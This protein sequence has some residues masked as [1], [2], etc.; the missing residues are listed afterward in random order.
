M[1]N[2]QLET[3]PAQRWPICPVPEPSM[4]QLELSATSAR[5]HQ[6]ILS[7]HRDRCCAVSLS[8][9]EADR[10]MDSE[11]MPNISISNSDLTS[12]AIKTAPSRRY[13]LIPILDP[14]SK[15]TGSSSS[16]SRNRIS[17][18]RSV[19]LQL[20]FKSESWTSYYRQHWRNRSFQDA[21]EGLDLIKHLYHG[22]TS[23]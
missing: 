19:E 8:T 4:P 11:C 13:R 12:N 1:F 9:A 15:P 22:T 18:V 5:S 21:G 14:L 3:W 7:P 10:E 17:T 2:L 20:F 6:F 16:W 23:G